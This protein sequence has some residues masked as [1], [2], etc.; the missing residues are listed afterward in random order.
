[1]KPI[2][3]LIKVDPGEAGYG[4]AFESRG[5]YDTVA[6]EAFPAG[7]RVNGDS[8]AVVDLLEPHNAAMPEEMRPGYNLGYGLLQQTMTSK[9]N[10]DF[11]AVAAAQAEA[12]AIA[13]QAS[14]TVKVRIRPQVKVLREHDA[15]D[16]GAD[17]ESAL[18]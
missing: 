2:P 10:A 3:G 13:I 15:I 7:R 11:V 1:M 5:V 9:A 4:V 8:V 6:G 12:D 14:R 18:R 17:V 16:A